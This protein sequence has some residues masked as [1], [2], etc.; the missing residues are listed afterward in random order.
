[1]SAL[2][3]SY[4]ERVNRWLIFVVIAGLLIGFAGVIVH[5]PRA[6]GLGLLLVA[7]GLWAAIDFR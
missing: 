1:M 3:P 2:S 7:A 6:I 5:E 4:T